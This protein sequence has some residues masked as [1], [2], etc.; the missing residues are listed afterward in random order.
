MGTEILSPNSAPNTGLLNSVSIAVGFLA[1]QE[2]IRVYHSSQTSC[3][4]HCPSLSLRPLCP[5]LTPFDLL[6]PSAFVPTNPLLFRPIMLFRVPSQLLH[7]CLLSFVALFIATTV[8]ANPLPVPIHRRVGPNSKQKEARVQLWFGRANSKGQWI[9]V[10][11]PYQAGEVGVL[12][13]GNWLAFSMSTAVNKKTAEVS[14]K[15]ITLNP[16]N[17]DALVRGNKYAQ[18]LDGKVDFAIDGILKVEAFQEAL[19]VGLE[20]IAYIENETNDHLDCDMTY[21]SA[22]LQVTE[23]YGFFQEG[24]YE[25]VSTSWD[26]IMGAY[27]MLRYAHQSQST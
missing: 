23:K 12:G 11:K 24:V 7:I 18:Y 10:K 25:K 22:A 14:H 13:F 21:I 5:T 8:V 1:G 16:P 17:S 3:Q 4:L 9:E 20:N 27:V 6:L 2:S 15:I 26:T 19:R